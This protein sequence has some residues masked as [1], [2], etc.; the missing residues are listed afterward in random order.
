MQA[1]EVR[2]FERPSPAQ[3]PSA[4][5][6]ILLLESLLKEQI[7]SGEPNCSPDSDGAECNEMA[8]ITWVDTQLTKNP[9]ENH[10]IHARTSRAGEGDTKHSIRVKKDYTCNAN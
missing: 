1:P 9:L 2:Q 5:F 7:G 4:A 3:L 6:H 10:K 8:Q